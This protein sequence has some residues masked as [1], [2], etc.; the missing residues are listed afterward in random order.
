MRK[1]WA[2][3]LAR[4]EPLSDD[5]R[6]DDCSP[7]WRRVVVKNQQWCTITLPS[8]VSAKS[9]SEPV[10]G[11]YVVPTRL[12]YRHFAIRLH[13]DSNQTRLMIVFRQITYLL[14][15]PYR[16]TSCS[17]ATLY[18]VFNLVFLVYRLFISK[19]NVLLQCS[20]G[21]APIERFPLTFNIIRISLNAS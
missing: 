1:A 2:S 6:F 10:D 8:S 11:V 5:V 14:Q 7:R 16:E 20:L 17:L 3:L 13:F 15:S 9:Y 19:I 12:R 21:D 4:G 18:F